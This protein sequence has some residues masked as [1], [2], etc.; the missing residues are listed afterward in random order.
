MSSAAVDITL[1][2]EGAIS[3]PMVAAL[4]NFDLNK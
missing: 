1:S 2:T 3:S 4:V